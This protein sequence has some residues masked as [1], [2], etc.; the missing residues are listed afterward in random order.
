MSDSYSQG[1]AAARYADA[2]WLDKATRE[3]T[4]VLEMLPDDAGAKVIRKKV[5]RA[6]SHIDHVRSKA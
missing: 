3:L 2:F 1:A 5:A 4:A 6:Q